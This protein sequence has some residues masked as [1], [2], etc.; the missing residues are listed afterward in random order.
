M[1][2]KSEKKYLDFVEWSKNKGNL[3]DI[4]QVADKFDV[5]KS[6]AFMWIKMA[7]FKKVYIKD[8]L[9]AS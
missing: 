8:E 4:Q 3:K 7:G 6:T 5:S 2:D 1:S 9:D